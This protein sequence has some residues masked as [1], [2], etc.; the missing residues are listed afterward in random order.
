LYYLFA[1]RVR[2]IDI[3]SEYYYMRMRAFLSSFSFQFPQSFGR[4][5]K[6]MLLARRWWCARSG[7]HFIFSGNNSGAREKERV[8]II[9]DALRNA[10]RG[11]GVGLRRGVNNNNNRRREFKTLSKMDRGN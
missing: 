9:A 6:F 11:G 10:P 2:V 3:F 4:F 1:A 7:S 5:C 8:P